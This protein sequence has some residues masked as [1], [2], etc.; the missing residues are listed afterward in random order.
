[1]KTGAR[2][3]VSARCL[4]L[5]YLIKRDFFDAIPENWRQE[6]LLH[7]ALNVAGKYMYVA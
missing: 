3:R 1:M 4:V 2:R 6:F 7:S 5:G